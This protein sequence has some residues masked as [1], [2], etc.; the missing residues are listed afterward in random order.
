VDVPRITLHAFVDEEAVK[1]IIVNLINNAIKYAD[2]KVSVRMLP[3]SSED[4]M[5]HIEFKN[6]GYKIPND[7]REKSLNHSSGSKKPK[8]KPEQA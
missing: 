3:F 2:K 1:K 5:F 6:D 4:S 8:K 7:L